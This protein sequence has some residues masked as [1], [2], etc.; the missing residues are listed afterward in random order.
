MKKSWHY[1]VLGLLI[2]AL[3]ASW[4]WQR[5][6][7]ISRNAYR[8]S[9]E[10]ATIRFNGLSTLYERNADKLTVC[11]DAANEADAAERASRRELHVTRVP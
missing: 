11:E 7:D 9:V 6:F 4:L 5:Q 10:N 2:G 1:L 3:G 8:A